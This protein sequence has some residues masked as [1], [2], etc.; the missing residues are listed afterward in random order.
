MSTNPQEHQ[1]VLEDQKPRPP[2]PADV[3]MKALGVLIAMTP[4]FY[5]AGVLLASMGQHF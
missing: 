5:C 2:A 3:V 4:L 1:S